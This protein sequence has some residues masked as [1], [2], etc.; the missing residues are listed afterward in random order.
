MTSRAVV[1]LCQDCEL[2]KKGE[3]AV[4][5]SI[6][7]KYM[8][9]VFPYRDHSREVRTGIDYTFLKVVP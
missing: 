2:G 9:L 3:R 6:K 8:T 7:G 4:V 1:E 5:L